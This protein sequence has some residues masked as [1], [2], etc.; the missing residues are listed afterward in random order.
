MSLFESIKKA[1]LGEPDKIKSPSIEVNPRNV[2]RDLTDD[3]ENGAL[4][5]YDGDYYANMY[6]YT[7]DNSLHEIQNK[8]IE[9]YRNIVTN[10]E[11]DNAVDMIV[12]EAIYTAS[13]NA[14]KINLNEENDRIKEKVYESFNKILKILNIKENVFPMFRQGYVDGQLNLAIVYDNSNLSKGIRKIYT[15][16]PYNLYFDKK[17]RKWKYK[18]N[19]EYYSYD[20]SL[21]VTLEFSEEELVHMD[22]GLYRKIETYDNGNK[23]M[24]R[25]NLGY[26]EKVIKTANLLES[27]ENLLVPYRYSRSVTRRLFNVDTGDMPPKKA[28]EYVNKIKTEFQ[29]KKSY[30][31]KEGTIRNVRATQPL[32]EDY[33]FS[34]RNGSRGTTVDTMDE[35]GSALDM[36]D[37]NYV[38][39]KLY[40]DLKIPSSRNPYS[41]DQPTFS[42]DNTQITQ[43]EYN[44]YVF[45]SRLRLPFVKMI[46]EILK[47]ELISTGVFTPEEYESYEE[48]IEISFQADALFLE[49][50][51]KDMFLKSVDA[52]DNIKEHIGEVISLESALKHT[53][54]WSD[55]EIEEEM[56]RIKKE[57]TDEKF[58]TFYAKKEEG[59]GKRW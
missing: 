16:E 46:K 52:F 47:R 58:S 27:L 36:E 53:M 6:N 57:K 26:L 15:L 7:F 9:K 30:D 50:M 42:F 2:T 13:E 43:Q 39:K 25:V 11:V 48:K 3:S 31:V 54:S 24:Y 55:E 41:D 33:W 1:F 23:V 51:K 56:G 40:Q 38:A 19:N 59:S 49:N 21:E 35:R 12:T 37:I 28:R 18:K 22:F 32:V 5:M 14:L 10:P 20:N 34:N 8:I 44:F 17:E 45:I 29:Y 4:V